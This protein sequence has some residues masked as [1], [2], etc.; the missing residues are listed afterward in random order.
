MG[1]ASRTV[2][3]LMMATTVLLASCTRYVD[4]ARA[5]AAADLSTAAQPG[6]SDATQCEAV[7]AP[8]TTIPARDDDEPVMKIPKPSG[9]QRS[10]MLDS[11]LIRFAMRNEALTSGSFTANVVVTFESAP[12]TQDADLVFA[13]MRDALE[14]GIGVTDVSV[15]ERSLCGVPARK[16]SYTMPVMGNVAP[17]PAVALGA[18]MHAEGM[19]YVVSVT[20]QTMDADDPTYQRDSETILDGFQFL[21]PSPE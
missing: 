9:W 18:V 2:A 13:T 10:T 4:D 12:G 6:G 5:V 17:H 19:T 16:F 1:T 8:L 3:V 21:P 15:T 14:S 20:A 7:D 11:P